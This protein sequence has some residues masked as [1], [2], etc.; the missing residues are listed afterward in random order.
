[1]PHNVDNEKHAVR[2]ALRAL[3]SWRTYANLVDLFEVN[4]KELCNLVKYS[5]YEPPAWVW[6]KLGL[7]VYELAP[8]CPVHGKAC[9]LDCTTE[10]PVPLEAKVTMPK[11][12][13]K[14][15]KPTPPRFTAYA[16]TPIEKIELEL[17]KLTGKRFVC[18]DELIEMEY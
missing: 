12:P 5:D 9:V 13:G 8:V 10:K 14:Q 3:K 16:G 17:L 6:I 1:M 4:Q 11:A 18:V 15:R 7:Q 2:M